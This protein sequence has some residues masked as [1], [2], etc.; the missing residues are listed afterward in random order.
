MN[1]VEHL[2]IQN[3]KKDIAFS[4]EYENGGRQRHGLYNQL[5]DSHSKFKD[6]QR[7]LADKKNRYEVRDFK[8]QIAN[9]KWKITAKDAEL[10]FLE[11]EVDKFKED[12]ANIRE[13]ADQKK[14]RSKQQAPY[15]GITS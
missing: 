1:D 3:D 8:E 7:E 9:S 4:S 11:K 12:L 14:R 6:L 5:Q 10:E 13:D 15:K 2:M